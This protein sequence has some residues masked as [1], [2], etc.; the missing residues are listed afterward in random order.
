MINRDILKGAEKQRLEALSR[1]NSADYLKGCIESGVEPEY[2]FLAEMGLA[3]RDYLKEMAIRAVEES[4]RFDS[5]KTSKKQRKPRKQK[6]KKE[7]I[8]VNPITYKEFLDEGEKYYRSDA[9]RYRYQRE[10]ILLKY[11]PRHFANGFE[12][13]SD[14]DVFGIY[15]HLIR[16]ARKVT[17]D[18]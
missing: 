5:T 3:E 7:R 17:Y 6:P 10:E 13:K 4:S 14:N 11:F 12:G 1:G 8:M 15:S 2:M 16:H 9:L 18:Q